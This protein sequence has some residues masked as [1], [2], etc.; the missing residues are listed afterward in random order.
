LS[1]EGIKLDPRKTAI[2]T[3]WLQPTNVKEL[4]SFLGFANW[5]TQYMQETF[6]TYN[7]IDKAHKKE[8]CLYLGFGM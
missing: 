8:S 1:K 5:F 3:D 6:T 2:V 4:Q 7:R